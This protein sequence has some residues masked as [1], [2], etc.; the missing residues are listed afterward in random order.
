MQITGGGGK[1]RGGPR[2][3]ANP[4]GTWGCGPMLRCSSSTMQ[5]TSFPPRASPGTRKPHVRGLCYYSDT[6]LDQD[7]ETDSREGADQ[8]VGEVDRLVVDE[9][10]G[11]ERR[12]QHGIRGRTDER[13]D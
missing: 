12:A 1:G 2:A 11:L 3:A 6:L 13:R 7:G 9:A 5:P 8:G 10:T 4:P